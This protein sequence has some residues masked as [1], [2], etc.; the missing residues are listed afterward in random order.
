MTVNSLKAVKSDYYACQ[1]SMRGLGDQ[2]GSGVHVYHRGPLVACHSTAP[3]PVEEYEAWLAAH[4]VGKRGKSVVTAAK[5]RRMVQM[6]RNG[7]GLV[8]IGR[9]CGG[10]SGGTVHKWLNLLPSGLSA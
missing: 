4:P 10:L 9:G 8:E 2:T 5:L 7:C 1:R 3:P 6:K